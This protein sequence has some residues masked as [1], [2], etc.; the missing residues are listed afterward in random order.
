MHALIAECEAY[1]RT[2]TSQGLGLFNSRVCV[3]TMHSG[4]LIEQ[5]CVG[6]ACC[7]RLTLRRLLL[8]LMSWV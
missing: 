8:L 3:F 5:R 4:W 6:Q 2:Y 7:G 1:Q